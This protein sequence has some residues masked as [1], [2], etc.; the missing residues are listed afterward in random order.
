MAMSSSP[1]L[2]MN[3]FTIVLGFRTQASGTLGS[4]DLKGTGALPL[5][6][7]SRTHLL[8]YLAQ[9]APSNW[10][11]PS[12]SVRRTLTRVTAALPERPGVPS[13]P[14]TRSILR[15]WLR[16]ATRSRGTGVSLAE[17]WPTHENPRAYLAQ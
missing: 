6:G 15:N 8:L 5:E 17:Q 2:P 10:L 13:L 4:S 1:F 16:T 9:H 14:R 11:H 3:S 7:G 12:P